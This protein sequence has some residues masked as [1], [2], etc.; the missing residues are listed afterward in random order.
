VLVRWSTSVLISLESGGAGESRD[1]PG[2]L[3]MPMPAPYMYL[4]EHIHAI[5]ENTI[6]PHQSRSRQPS[7]VAECRPPQFRAPAFH[8][9]SIHSLGSS[10]T[11]HSILRLDTDMNMLPTYTDR[12]K[13]THDLLRC[14]MHLIERGSRRS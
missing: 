1:A 12:S 6:E 5:A 14:G 7:A 3:W 4:N 11:F 13:P 8:S 10:F 2:S 9:I